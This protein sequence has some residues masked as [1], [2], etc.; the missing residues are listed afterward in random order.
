MVEK[1]PLRDF[2]QVQISEQQDQIDRRFQHMQEQIDRRLTAD[3]ELRKSD[4]AAI[5]DRLRE[6]NGNAART[7]EERSHFVSFETFD[8]FKDSVVAALAAMQGTRLGI[9]QLWGYIIGA[10]GIVAAI[11]T[12]VAVLH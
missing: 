6:L 1:V 12:V 9:S 10:F 11:V 2:V 7:R 5:T 8:P 3:A 4:Q